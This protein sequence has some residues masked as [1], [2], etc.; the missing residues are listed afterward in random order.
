[1]LSVYNLDNTEPCITIVEGLN[2]YRHK[3]TYKY[4]H[5][6]NCDSVIISNFGSSL[7]IVKKKSAVIWGSLLIQ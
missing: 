2:A 1:M 5:M 4:T 3:Y 6:C 7:Y